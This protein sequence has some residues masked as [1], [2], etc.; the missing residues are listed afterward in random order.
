MFK[1]GGSKAVW[2]MLKKTDDLV[3]EGVP[4]CGRGVGG[5][6]TGRSLRWDWRRVL[7]NSPGPWEEDGLRF[8]LLSTLFF[9][10]LL[11]NT[12]MLSG[13]IHV[14]LFGRKQAFDQIWEKLDP[15]G[16][17]STRDWRPVLVLGHGRMEPTEMFLGESFLCFW[18]WWS[19]WWWWWW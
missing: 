9:L 2:T 14:A 12:Q 18:L 1:K 8:T 15:T 4:K 5:A 10:S 11:R 16:R 6:S 3:R 19:W 7:E 13:K 17:S